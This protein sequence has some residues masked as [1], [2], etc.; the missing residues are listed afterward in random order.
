LLGR[1]LLPDDFKPGNDHVLVL[2]QK[3]WQRVFGG[4]A[5]VVGRSITLSGESYAVV[6]VMPA[7]FHFPPFWST[8]AEMWAPL[9]LS[10][11]ATSRGGN[12]LRVF[13]RLK[14]GVTQAQAQAE[15]DA[16]NAKLAQ[17][18][19][20]TNTGIDIRVDSVE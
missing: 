19:P 16:M 15:A 9:D 20:D 8:R 18:Y 17:G 14:P 4:D 7:R 2:S 3:L 1:T 5:A 12:S 10:S 6:G 11:R 13:A